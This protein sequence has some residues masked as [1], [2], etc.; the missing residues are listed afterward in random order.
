MVLVGNNMGGERQVAESEAREFAAT[1]DD[2]I[3]YFETDA[4]LEREESGVVELMSH[5]L[6]ISYDYSKAS[7]MLGKQKLGFPL[8]PSHHSE[9]AIKKEKAKKKKGAAEMVGTW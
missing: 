2:K 4:R 8:R 5:I 9:S 1:I 7:A 3:V 6:K